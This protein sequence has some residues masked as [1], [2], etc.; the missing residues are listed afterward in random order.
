MFLDVKNHSD[1]DF[2]ELKMAFSRRRLMRS[3]RKIICCATLVFI[4]FIAYVIVFTEDHRIKEEHFK[5]LSERCLSNAAE[6]LLQALV[7]FFY[8]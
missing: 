5:P 3:Q 4:L 8:A 6:D 7:S 1:Y 2:L